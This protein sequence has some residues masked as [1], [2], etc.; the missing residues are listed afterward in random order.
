MFVYCLN[1]PV[2][3][4]DNS[5]TTAVTLQQWFYLLGLLPFVDGPLP[6]GDVILVASLWYLGDILF[7]SDD[8]SSGS[9][10]N[11]TNLSYGH[12]PPNPDDNDDDELIEYYD[13]ESNFGGRQRIGKSNGKTPRN[14]Q[15]QNK[16]FKDATKGL[17]PKQKRK[18]H[19][20]ITK[21]GLGYHGIKEYINTVK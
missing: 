1:C 4:R 10:D 8:V 6:F 14:N 20:A 18:V 15:A 9:L 21:K 16:Q 7:S 5:G 19:D 2:N 11:N 12:T 3:L 13:H 17:T